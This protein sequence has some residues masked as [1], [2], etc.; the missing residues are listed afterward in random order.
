[1]YFYFFVHEYFVCMCVQAP[2]VYL[3]PT[4]Q[5]RAPYSL[6]AELQMVMICVC[7]LGTQ[8]RPS[9]RAA[10]VLSHRAISPVPGLMT[11]ELRN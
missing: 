4:E 7:V 11:A 8:P 2:C 3:V 9:A 1:M 5:K 6:E 10:S